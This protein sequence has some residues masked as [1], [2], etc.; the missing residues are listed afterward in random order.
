[1]PR[2]ALE[3]RLFSVVDDA[4]YGYGTSVHLFQMC[5]N[6]YRS[7]VLLLW[8]STPCSKTMF[9]QSME[10]FLCIQGCVGS[11]QKL[12]RFWEAIRGWKLDP[13]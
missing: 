3:E 8:M 2:Q 4:G 13:R 11:Q 6:Y 9:A 10:V 5:C 1:M 7:V 12:G